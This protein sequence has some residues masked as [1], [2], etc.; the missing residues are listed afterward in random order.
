MPMNCKEISKKNLETY[1]YNGSCEA[2][3]QEPLLR[4]CDAAEK[5]NNKKQHYAQN[6]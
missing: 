1:C 4:T 6:I 2:V 3:T 5:S